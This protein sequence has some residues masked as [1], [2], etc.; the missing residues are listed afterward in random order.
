[1]SANN[2]KKAVWFNVSIINTKLKRVTKKKNKEK[3]RYRKGRW[4]A[5]LSVNNC[6]KAVWFNV[7]II[8]TKLKIVTKK[9][10]KN[11]DTRKEDE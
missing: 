2:C 9:K 4:V 5:E 7:P 11:K 3:Q 8:K 6:N 10:N 1:M